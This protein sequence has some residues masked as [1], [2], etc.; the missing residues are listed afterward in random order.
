MEI[1]FKKECQMY[2][3]LQLIHFGLFCKGNNKLKLLA[4]E[5]DKIKQ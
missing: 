3:P 5:V 1:L 4:G 2:A